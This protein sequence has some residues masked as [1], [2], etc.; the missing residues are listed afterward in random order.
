M[1]RN[2]QIIFGNIRVQALSNTLLRFE[3]RGAAGFEDRPTFTVLERDF[4]PPECL[5]EKTEQGTTL[6]TDSYR[7]VVSGGG[8]LDDVRVESSAGALLYQ[9]DGQV[10]GAADLPSPGEEMTV[11]VMAD[12]PRIVPPEW[13][14]T[15]PPEKEAESPTSGWDIGNDAPDVYIFIPGTGGY[16]Q[17]RRDFLCLT[18]PIPL[19]P[20]FAFGLIDS[21]Y[22]PYSEESALGTIDKYR[23]KG[24]PLDV[25]VVDT[26]WRTGASH[27]YRVNEDLFPD[28]E[29]FIQRAHAR[30]VRLLFNDHPEPHVEG[31]LDP[32]ELQYRYEGLT[33]LLGKGADVWW[34]DRNWRVHLDTPVPG[35]V[36]D[37]WG[38]RLYH[39]ITARFRPARRPLIMSNVAGIEH[40]KRLTPA[41]PAE[42]RY[43]IWWT[44]DTAAR[45]DFLRLGMQN[46]VDYGTAG[47]M[48]YVHEDL[49][50]HFGNPNA[51]L[52]VRFVQFGVFSPVCRLHCTRAETR[53]PWAFGD[54]A[55][56]IT[57]D[58]IRL[59]YRLQP[60]IYAAARQAHESGTPILRRLDLEW[61]E[62][63]E[64]K[65]PSQYLFGEDLLVAPMHTGRTDYTAIGSDHL[66]TPDG[67]PGVLGEYFASASMGVEPDLARVDE[68]IDINWD[69][70]DFP[71]DVT[72]DDF[73]ARWTGR[74]VEVPETGIY[75]L[76]VYLFGRL[77]IALNGEQIME[78]QV[79]DYAGPIAVPVHL[80][81]DSSNELL[82]EYYQTGWK[83]MMSLVWLLPSKATALPTRDVWLPP[84]GW[85]DTW[86]GLRL[87][88]PALI[89]VSSELWH[90]PIYQREG[91]VVFSLP[92][93]QHTGECPWDT[94]IL[95]AVVPHADTT[96]TR[97]L[98]EDDG[99]ST[100]YLEGAF[101]KT[102]VLLEREGTRVL[103]RIANM[104]GEFPGRLKERT[105]VLRL[106]LPLG[107]ALQE[108]FLDGSRLNIPSST[109][110]SVN[111]TARVLLPQV[112]GSEIP[113][114]GQGTPPGEHA[115]VLLEVIV[116][117]RAVDETIELVVKL[118]QEYPP[119]KM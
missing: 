115:G 110:S 41:H 6:I 61:P 113:F 79:D 21:R 105:W 28:I 45:W 31:A 89:Q 58:Y 109:G 34:Y 36:R 55:E 12:S 2:N 94:L 7:V 3:E 51:E 63:P 91:G 10:P 111:V 118:V 47:L 26:D 62:Y 53:F 74:L 8:S 19:P 39:D 11:W 71:E 16:A 104:V 29:K 92:Q 65:D 48:P 4:S 96:V 18:G 40:G 72:G 20:L 117:D 56:Q 35:F 78:Q 67:G 43:P 59:R 70:F 54:E 32:Q 75:S 99:I 1:V 107:E 98:Y 88:G 17:F 52:Y 106:H 38:Q 50:G 27:G 33:S 86:S 44:G 64:A 90:T 69:R 14:A 60:V 30:H 13:G 9:Y 23:G 80:K 15:P 112:S 102:P 5:I 119:D 97:T 87:E 101:C 66:Q 49:G 46:A 57:G 82:V 77:R 85:M 42:H 100:A 81:K 83:A 68:Q 93:M 108:L 24:I 116:P 22:Y 25:F 73:S 37:V 95:D 114:R 76:G 103:L 84:G